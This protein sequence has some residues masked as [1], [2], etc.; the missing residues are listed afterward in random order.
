MR[1]N[2]PVQNHQRLTVYEEDAR[3]LRGALTSRQTW[4]TCERH[5]RGLWVA[6]NRFRI[7]APRLRFLSGESGAHELAVED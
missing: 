1:H 2:R 4:T 5:R 3:R 7:E 6:F